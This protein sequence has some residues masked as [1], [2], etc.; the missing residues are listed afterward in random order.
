M[1]KSRIN[2]I[3]PWNHREDF[4]CKIYVHVHCTMQENN[5]DHMAQ[6]HTAVFPIHVF[7]SFTLFVRALHLLNPCVMNKS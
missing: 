1:Y 4:T 3:G 5:V 6:A 7:Y 2:V